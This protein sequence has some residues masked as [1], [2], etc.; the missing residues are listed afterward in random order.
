[1]NILEKIVTYKREEV[2][3][4]KIE[5][6]SVL[7]EKSKFFKRKPLSLKRAVVDSKRNGIIAE[8]KRQSPSRGV[9]NKYADPAIVCPRY[10]EAGASALSVLTDSKYFGGSNTDLLAVRN[11]CDAPILR[12]EFII[13]EYPVVEAKSIGADA[14]LLIADILTAREMKILAGV[15]RDLVALTD[16]RRHLAVVGQRGQKRER[17]RAAA[18]GDAERTRNCRAV[19]NERTLRGVR[20]G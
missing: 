14:I 16:V 5:N 9:I 3:R 18:V 19:C 2:G 17:A 1:M 4:L 20:R 8:F 15:A 6:P 10:L 13:D 12:K 11:L 7:L